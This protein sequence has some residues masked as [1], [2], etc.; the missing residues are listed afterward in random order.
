MSTAGERVDGA[1]GV[2]GR[3]RGKRGGT[4]PTGGRGK[5]RGRRPLSEIQKQENG[6]AREL[7][8]QKVCI[9][10]LQY[11]FLSR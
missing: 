4:T 6:V 7:M 5:G 2:R 9:L 3:G 10:G 8:K 11:Y 1:R